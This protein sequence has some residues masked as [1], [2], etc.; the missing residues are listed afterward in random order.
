MIGQSPNRPLAECIPVVE[1]ALEIHRSMGNYREACFAVRLLA[2]LV[3]TLDPASYPRGLELLE[4]AVE[5]ARAV[6]SLEDEARALIVRAGL[7]AVERPRD[8]VIADY[9][10]AVE[11]VERLRDLQPDNLVRARLLWDWA[12][13]YYRMAGYLLGGTPHERTPFSASLHDIDLAFRTIESLRARILLDAM[14]SAQAT[15]AINR[16]TPA[17][18]ELTPLLERIQELRQRLDSPGLARSERDE[19]ISELTSLEAD[20]RTHRR[21]AAEA[22]PAYALL[23][24][25]EIPGI[26]QLQESLAEDEALVLFQLSTRRQDATH[27]YWNGGSYALVVTRDRVEGE[28]LEDA[29]LL[30]DR[31]AMFLGLLP[32]R[33]ELEA[34][35]AA[36]LYEDLLG[37]LLRKVDRSRIRRLVVVPDGSLHRLPFGALRESATEDPMAAHYA[38]SSVPSASLW[39]QRR[40]GSDEPR[41]S[42]MALADPDLPQPWDSAPPTLRDAFGPLPSARAEARAWA[43]AVGGRR[44]LLTGA[45]ATEAA[46]ARADLRNVGLLHFAT[47]ALVDPLHP[48]NSAIV[49]APGGEEDGLL[50]IREIV[51]MDLHGT[52]VVM[53]ACASATG[54]LTRG[55]GVLGLARAF[56]QAGADTVIATLWPVRDQEAGRFMFDVSQEVS[57][58]QTIGDAF[59]EVQR[60]W[61]GRGEPTDSWAGFVLMGDTRAALAPATSRPGF[62][63]ALVATGAILLVLLAAA[64]VIRRSP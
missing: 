55:E 56:F 30:E 27:W 17:A 46:L 3:V 47:H 39:Y 58:G 23:R 41:H 53:S 32:R 13:I 12:F 4:Q 29:D 19:A 35:A 59:D 25:P 7:G 26:D 36:S 57:R 22:D 42:V 60:A 15:E 61:I 38:I 21:D 43:E 50:H 63:P 37:P 9:A 34:E 49:L 6:G 62:D 8:E 18:R 45:A 51:D 2:R 20:E 28:A 10:R 48:E 54:E 64:L 1:E 31:V 24:R 33:D 40:R 44:R 52:V 5:M 11:A 16:R 14:D